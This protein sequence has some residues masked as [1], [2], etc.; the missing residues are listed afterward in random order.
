MKKIFFFLLLF[1]CFT[2][3]AQTVTVTDQSNLQ[4]IV[5]LSIYNAQFFISTNQNGEAD[6]SNFKG[7]D[8]IKFEH[9]SYFSAVFSYKELS[10]KGFKISLSQKEYSIEEIVISASKFEDKRKDVAQSIQVLKAKDLAFINQQTTADVMQNSGNVM[11]Q[12]SQGGGGSP[13]IRGFETNKVLM[14]IDGVRMNNAIYRGGHLQNIITIDNSMLDKVEIVF[15]P[16]SVIYGSDAL[17]GVMHFYSRNP[18]LS[19]TGTQLK[20]NAFARYATVNQENTGHI[21]F[22]VGKKRFASLTSITFSNFNDLRQGNIRNPFYGS[23]GARNFYVEKINGKDSMMVNSDPNVQVGSGYSQYDIL[24][25]FLFKQSAN[26]K[27]ILNLQ[28]STS[29]NIPRYDRLTQ[30]SGNNPKFGDWYYGPQER[31]FASYSLNLINGNTIYNNARIIVAYQ[32][33]EESRN[34]RRFQ[35]TTLNHRIEQL[36]IISLN[37]DFDKKIKKNEMR[38]GVEAVYNKVNS[39]ANAENIVTGVS[40]PLDTRYPDGG[41]TMQSIAGY[42]SH[43]LELSKKFIINDGIRISNVRLTSLF[44][45]TTFFP[46]PFNSVTQNNT[47]LNGNLG[48]VAMHGKGWRMTLIGASGFRAP[49]V[50]DLSKVFESTTGNVIVPNPD[51]KPEFT[52]NLDLGISKTFQEKIILGGNAFYTLY[53]NAITTKPGKFNGLDSVMYDGQ[54]SA[55]SMNVNA[56]EA[57]L[58]G[59]S[60]Y[61]NADITKQFSIVSTVNYTY[62]RI[63]TDSPDYPLD[64]IPPVFGKTS[65]ILK[66]KKFRGELFLMYSGWKRLNDYNMYGED[67]FFGNATAQGMPAWLTFNARAAYQVQKNLQIQMALENIFDVN[68]RVF[69]SN[70]SAPG[71]NFVLTLRGNF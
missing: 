24:Q 33:I 42:F 69:A 30:T 29:S 59:V 67:N 12:K 31:L 36:D 51:L 20:V 45:D 18:I 41:S 13:I 21:D 65:F 26:V 61:F 53:K 52:Y 32:N 14:V 49:N 2:S 47:A 5:A 1:V 27:H 44:N 48:F 40:T 46:F 34:D 8:S 50:D 16:G 19:D 10:E 63:K 28:Y 23:L 58:Y 9:V 22:N 11:V 57:Y 54:M 56:N 6:I 38:F 37:A 3:Y 71:R 25:K 17:G 35:K 62:G 55:V 70:I 60:L 4:P 43:T 39:T 7:S 68:Y 64:H 15:G 66:Q